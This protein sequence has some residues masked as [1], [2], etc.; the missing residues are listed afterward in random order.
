MQK[1]FFIGRINELKQLENLT[2]KRTSSLVVISGRRRIGKSRLVEEFA[3][4]YRFIRFSGLPPTPRVTAQDQRDEFARQLAKEAQYPLV[5]AKDWGDL[6]SLL[7]RE[8][9]NGRVI[10]L[11]DEISWMGSKD[12]LF[13]GKLKN[14]WDME[15]KSNPELIV[16]LCG[17]VSSWI[18]KNILKSTGFMGRVSLP[19]E[20]QQL[21]LLECNQLLDAVGFSG[22]KWDKFKILSITG[23][24]PRYLEEVQAHM[25]AEANIEQLCFSPG[26]I[27]FREFDDMFF[28]LFSK[29]SNTYKKIVA[30]LVNGSKELSEIAEEVKLSTGG[31]L[32]SSLQDLVQLGF[33]RRDY[34]WNLK[35]GKESGL[36]HFRLT[37]N[38][39]RF[40]LKYIQPNH[41]KIAHK[42]SSQKFFHETII[43]DSI[44]GLQFENLVLA[45]RKLIWDKLPLNP[46]QIVNDNPFF[47]RNT[48]RTKGCQIDYLIQYRSNLF[49]CEIKFSKNP[50][51]LGIVE[52][53]KEKI[54]K[55]SKPRNFSCYPVLI[56]VNGVSDA[57]VDSNYFVEIIDFSS[58]L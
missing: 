20:L 36:S 17:S 54:N 27:L 58:F 21:G 8:T 49:V 48:K 2:K 37:D 35:E 52:E 57:V 56:H 25:P 28:D 7:A 1:S 18:E 45:N 12:P 41:A 29:R 22:S 42:P 4:K 11:L 9:K 34:V 30:A 19:L 16:I 53:M 39:L 5:H 31:H 24:I 43:S 46:S 10:I 15:L 51:G 3:K 26:G 13:L 14:A 33:I 6:F 32:S 38:Y 50:I 47:Q 40:Y 44:L 55:L 23:G